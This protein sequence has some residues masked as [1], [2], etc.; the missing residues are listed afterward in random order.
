MKELALVAPKHTLR[1]DV[2]SLD[3]VDT[4]VKWLLSV[5]FLIRL[6]DIVGVQNFAGA[7]VIESSHTTTSLLYYGRN[8]VNDY[9][10]RFIEGKGFP[11]PFTSINQLTVSFE[12]EDDLIDA[13]M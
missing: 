5:R 13:L 4:M 2:S 10:T 8:E 9:V 7:E 1:N 11:Q 6:T 3:E 12:D